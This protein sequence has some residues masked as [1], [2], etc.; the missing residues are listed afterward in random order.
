MEHRLED[1]TMVHSK[2]FNLSFIGKK[3]M[4]GFRQ[5][6]GTLLPGYKFL[7]IVVLMNL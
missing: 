5:M 2:H 7:P 1:L 4:G 6:V 3:H